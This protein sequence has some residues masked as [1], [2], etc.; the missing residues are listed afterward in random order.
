MKKVF[1]L[2]LSVFLSLSAISQSIVYGIY[3]DSN[4]PYQDYSILATVEA[5]SGTIIEK[6]TILGYEG[7]VLGSSSFDQLSGNYIYLAAGNDGI[8]LLSRNVLQ[9]TTVSA[10]QPELGANAL[11]FD[12]ASGNTYGLGYYIVDSVAIDPSQGWYEYIYGT[13][14][15]TLDM[16]TGEG[17]VIGLLPEVDA[18]VVGASCFDTNNSMYYFIG[19]SSAN[20]QT[21]LYGV[22]ALT[23]S[24]DVAISMDLGPNEYLN[25][26]EYD[27]QGDVFYAVHRNNTGTMHFAQIDPSDG[28]IYDLLDISSNVQYFTPDATV[29]QQDNDQFIM[30]TVNPNTLLTIDADNATIVSQ[31]EID[32]NIIELE[33]DNIEFA[34][35][36]FVSVEEY[37]E[38]DVSLFPNPSSDYILIEG[39]DSYNTAFR[40]IDITGSVVRTGNLQASQR[41]SVSDLLEG[42]YFL[43]LADAHSIATSRFIVK[44]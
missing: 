12:M 36:Q 39:I 6:D 4:A 24:L 13:T 35:A 38:I 19:I 25:E 8:D 16:L 26:L 17:E 21:M 1:T 22:N 42:M 37:D 9:N 27:I 3:T 10:V 34:A 44:H 5:T 40:I 23:G 18:V 11:Q 43:E 2:I 31:A 14:F 29:Y 30:L 28:T 32:Y 20:Y 7:V 41:L 33:V 15:L